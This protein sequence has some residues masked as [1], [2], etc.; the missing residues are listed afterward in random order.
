MF[1]KAA[2]LAK[3]ASRW[4]IHFVFG[5]PL[6]AVLPFSTNSYRNGNE[7]W[8]FL[9]GNS[10]QQL[11]WF[12]GVL[13]IWVVLAI[14]ACAASKLH[15]IWLLVSTG[16]QNVALDILRSMGL[17]IIVTLISWAIRAVYPVGQLFRVAFMEDPMWMYFPIPICG[18]AYCCLSLMER[19]RILQV[20]QI[21][22][23]SL[24][25]FSSQYF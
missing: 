2:H 20:S 17:Y 8:C 7:G 19:K 12:W 24:R 16:N 18:I 13:V 15:A 25:G 21:P 10:A 14:V 6:I 4:G 1:G 5:F 3:F 23:C 9:Y 11:G 22:H